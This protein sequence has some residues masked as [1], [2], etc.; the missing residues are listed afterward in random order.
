MRKALLTFAMSA[1]IGAFMLPGCKSP[2]KKVEDARENL[3]EAKH[4]LRKAQED[5]IRARQDSLADVERFR[6]EEIV[7]VNSN[8]SAIAAIRAHTRAESKAIRDKNQKKIDELEARNNELKKQLNTYS[9]DD[10]RGKSNW[11]KFK[12]DFSRDMDSLGH[13]IKNLVSSKKK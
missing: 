4:D 6:R 9:Y 5:S 8:D 3:N 11:R 10:D 7:R 1:V 12:H 2:E 13:D